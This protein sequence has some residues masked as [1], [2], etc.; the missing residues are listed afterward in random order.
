MKT[1]LLHVFII[2]LLATGCSL[3]EP[4]PTP[5]PIYVTATPLV[6]AV[7]EAPTATPVLAPTI[8]ASDTPPDL[9]TLPP[10]T[11]TATLPPL[12][13][14]TA[15]F[16]PSFT[17]TVAPTP[18][19]VKCTATPA[20]GFG[21]IYHKDKTLAQGLGCPVGGNFAVNSASIALQNGAMLWVSQ[22]GDVPTRM[23]YALY[24]NATY[25][26]YEDTWVEH[27][28]PE[29]TGEIAPAG[30]FTPA[31]GFGKV[32]HNNPVVKNGLGWAKGTEVGTQGQIQRFE[33]GEMLFV[34]S[35]GQTFIFTNTA[36]AT[37]GTWRSDPTPF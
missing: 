21:T 23:I 1:R 29:T 5:E 19:K 24:S 30:F 8:L 33:R 9:P 16:T 10:P 36:G 14:L 34:A 13:T 27:V 22:F 25:Q 18:T 2:S 31:R 11:E 3:I 28:D 12:P 17:D 32:W 26:R 4:R 15:S 6:M 37:A 20:G 7:T 35:L